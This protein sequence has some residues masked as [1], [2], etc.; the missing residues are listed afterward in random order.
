MKSTVL[1]VIAF[2]LGGLAFYFY[3]QIN[4]PKITT[5]PTPT[6]SQPQPTAITTNPNTPSVKPKNN[7]GKVSGRLS[8]PSEMIP[9]L[10]IVAFNSQNLEEYE[11]IKTGINQSDYEL[12]LPKGTYF[13]V[14]Y[15]ADESGNYG[16]GYTNAVACGLSVECEDHSLVE[17]E[18]NKDTV[19][20]NID[21]TDWYAPENTFPDKP[22]VQ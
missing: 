10:L 9:E 6:V 20:Q 7:M 3:S 22:N 16:G 14:S 4:N 5:K 15:V 18:V 8:Y 17:V 13:L 21:L 19:I 1:T 2:I 12:E 11:Y